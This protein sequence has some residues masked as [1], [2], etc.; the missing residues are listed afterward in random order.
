MSVDESDQKSI[1][2]K[3]GSE[4]TKKYLI[5]VLKLSSIL[6]GNRTRLFALF[7]SS[8]REVIL[9]QLVERSLPTQMSRGSNPVIDKFYIPTPQH[10]KEENRENELIKNRMQAIPLCYGNGYGNDAR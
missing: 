2:P 6:K 4:M 3:L 7:E 9:A 5:S 8:S 10:L 1:R